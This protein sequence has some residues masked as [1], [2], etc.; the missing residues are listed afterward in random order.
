MIQPDPS[1]PDAKTESSVDLLLKAQGGDKDALNRLLVRYLPRLKRWATGRLQRGLRTMVD[2]GDLVQDAV[3]A[4][5][6]HLDKLE[7]RT[8]R[9][10]EFYLQRA[11]KNRIIDLYKR[12]GR[13]PARESI[14][15]QVP[16]RDV[17][18]YDAALAAEAYDRYQRAL[19]SLSKPDRCAVVSRLELGLGYEEIAAQ[20]RKPTPDAARVAVSRAIVRL[21]DKM[22]QPRRKGSRRRGF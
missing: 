15:D 4:A 11:V 22:S 16:A 3:V 5:L 14:S 6:P 12:S 10:L 9:A 18:P 1:M 2:T 7:I 13:R 8:E 20:L 17:S 21:A 19:A